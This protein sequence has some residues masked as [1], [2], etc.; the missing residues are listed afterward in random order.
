MASAEAKVEI[1]NKKSDHRLSPYFCFGDFNA[2][3][4]NEAI[5]R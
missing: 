2:R 4:E 5:Y 1:T 3:M